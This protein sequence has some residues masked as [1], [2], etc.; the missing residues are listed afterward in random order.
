MTKNLFGE[1]MNPDSFTYDKYCGF[2]GISAYQ[3]FGLDNKLSK[4]FVPLGWCDASKLKIRPRTGIA[5]MLWSKEF[6]E[7]LWCHYFSFE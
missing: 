6:K 2:V 5:I 4:E 3:I 7:E 1:E